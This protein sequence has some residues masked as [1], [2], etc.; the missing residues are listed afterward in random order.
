MKLN[1]DG[2]L[3]SSCGRPI[4]SM[5]SNCLTVE[6]RGDVRK[7]RDYVLEGV[8]DPFTFSHKS[9]RGMIPVIDIIPEDLFSISGMKLAKKY[10]I[11]AVDYSVKAGANVILLAAST[12][13]LFGNGK[14]LKEMY[15][16]TIFTI[17][18]NGTALAFLKQ[19]EYATLNISYNSPVIVLGA[20]FLGNAALQF[21]EQKGYTNLIVISRHKTDYSS[22]MSHYKSLTDYI[23]SADFD[24]AELLLCCAH[25]HDI[26]A[27]QLRALNN[28][29]LIVLD[30]AVPKAVPNVVA[31]SLSGVI[32]R[33]DGGDFEIGNLKLDFP[34]EIVGLNF[35][36]EFYGCFTEALYLAI[37]RQKH[38]CNFFEVSDANMDIVYQLIK[39]Y[40]DD[41]FVSLKS[42]G[43]EVSNHESVLQL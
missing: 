10:F 43:Q 17:G 34:P 32:S 42:F 35:E 27:D 41:V 31:S 37:S 26:Q 25:N 9:D 1:N 22:V 4:V 23:D 12:K 38:D 28:D 29:N 16:D 2:D 24:G 33:F 18:D 6:H 39:P 36:G 8:F 40:S 5:I 21:L 14:E 15:P 11:N 13:R 30:V 7:Q 19:I 3:K 20:G